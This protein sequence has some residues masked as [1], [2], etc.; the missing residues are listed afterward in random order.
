MFFENNYIY[1]SSKLIIYSISNYK[2]IMT[3]FI[4]IFIKVNKSKYSNNNQLITDSLIY[5]K[6]YLYYKIKNCIYNDNIMNIIYD[7]DYHLNNNI[8]SNEK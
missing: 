4:N 5:S 7:I 2:N 8:L 6:Y 3:K 1:F